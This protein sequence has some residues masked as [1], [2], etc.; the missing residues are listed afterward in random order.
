MKE[1][2]G[3][4]IA[5][6][7]M[8]DALYYKALG[9]AAVDELQT[10]GGQS[11]ILADIIACLQDCR[12]IH[13]PFNCPAL[14]EELPHHGIEIVTAGDQYDAVYWG[15]PTI[16]DDDVLFPDCLSDPSEATKWNKE[17]E[18][19]TSRML[20]RFAMEKGAKRLI[21]GLGTG[22]IS[23]AERVEDMMG[24]QVVSWKR[25]GDFE[26]WVIVRNLV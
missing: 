4:V 17:V 24:G 20:T 6:E 9:Y 23:V 5:K 3:N 12:T 18:R 13:I 16:V 25:F 21:S 19:L 14:E 15:T 26:D 7:A 11:L 1:N 10:S 2:G 8:S 22:D